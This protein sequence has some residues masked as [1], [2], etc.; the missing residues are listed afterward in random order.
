M[1]SRQHIIFQTSAQHLSRFNIFIL[2]DSSSCS[3]KIFS[4]ASCLKIFLYSCTFHLQSVLHHELLLDV[5]GETPNANVTARR[6]STSRG[7][8]QLLLPR[9]KLSIDK[10]PTRTQ[11]W[12]P[13]NIKCAA[14]TQ[15]RYASASTPAKPLTLN[16]RPA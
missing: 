11:C 5:D 12:Q 8:Q 10:S 16:A 15:A 14:T 3:T 7:L 6:S 9:S 2:D 4:A 1:F 13:R